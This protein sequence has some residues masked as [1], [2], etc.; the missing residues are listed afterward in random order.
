MKL[1]YLFIQIVTSLFGY[2]ETSFENFF[3][4][5]E[6]IFKPE[7]SQALLERLETPTTTTA[8]TKTAEVTVSSNIADCIEQENGCPCL[9]D[10]SEKEKLNGLSLDDISWDCT[11][12]SNQYSICRKTCNNNL[13]LSASRPRD[14]LECKCNS[15]GRKCKWKGIIQAGITDCT[16][17]ECHLTE[18]IKY[19]TLTLTQTNFVSVFMIKST[20]FMKMEL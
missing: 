16:P 1:V 5:L 18:R 13:I 7:I 17:R 19:L 14:E 4:F 9:I 11:S 6:N 3:N 10:L 12:G 20:V 15:K 8:T 2:D